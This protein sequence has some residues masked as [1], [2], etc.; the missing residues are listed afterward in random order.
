M[1]TIMAP[2]G[3]FPKLLYTIC[4]LLGDF[5]FQYCVSSRPWKS[6]LNRIRHTIQSVM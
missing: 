6:R 2:S 1:I 5:Y 3:N 4:T